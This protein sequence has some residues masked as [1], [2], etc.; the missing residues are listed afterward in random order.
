MT[1]N[2]KILGISELARILEKRGSRK[3]VHCHGVFDLLHIGHIRYFEQAKQAGD[4]LVVTLTPDRFVDKGPQRPAFDEHLRAEGLASP[5]VVDYVAVNPWRTAEETLRLLRPDV[6]AKGSEF[7]D[8]ED[9]RIG[10]IGP[11]MAVI[12]EIGGRMLF[13]EDIVFSSSNLINRF[14]S[15][16]SHEQQEYMQLFRNRHSLEDIEAVLDRMT[17]LRVLVIGDAIMDEYNYGEAM[18]KSSKEPVLALRHESSDLFAGGV[19]AVANHVAG[20]TG[21]V[22]LACLLGDRDSHEKLIRDSLADNVTP[23]FFYQ[24]DAPTIVKRRF[25]DT[26]SLNKLL[27]IYVMDDSG[28]DPES[29]KAFRK[30]IKEGLGGYDLVIVAD[31]GHGAI[32]QAMADMLSEHAPY[33]AVNTQANAGNRGFH[34]I[35]RYR[36]ADF[37]SLASHEFQLEFRGSRRQFRRDM[38]TLGKRLKSSIIVVTGGQTGCTV[39]DVDGEYARVPAF[40]TQAVDRVGAGD[41]FL[42]VAALAARLDAD[43]ELLGFIGNIAGALA[44]RVVGNKES[45]G[46]EQVEKFASALMK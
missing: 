26:P 34:T 25:I 45:I 12:K 41:A 33:L 15:G 24:K 32:S 35:S 1:G 8:G 7:K 5:P 4:I 18:G 20:F 3:V 36:K 10:K 17:D 31:Y 19:I 28:L 13:T 29:D 14:L 11:E 27:E 39:W 23:R 42:S 6:Y 2:K 21:S 9:N 43:R 22:D 37:V 16:M 40:S 46:K 30:D 38:D 44:V